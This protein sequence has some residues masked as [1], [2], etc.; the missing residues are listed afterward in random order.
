MTPDFRSARMPL[1]W[2]ALA[3]MLSSVPIRAQHTGSWQGFGGSGSGCMGE[4]NALVR[5]RNGD[6]Y[7][8]GRLTAC[9]GVPV[10][11]VARWDGTEW[12]A[13]TPELTR[14]ITALA[15]GPD[16]ELYVAE[17]L[18]QNTGTG[19]QPWTAVV[20]RWDGL[21]W[22]YV[23]QRGVAIGGNAGIRSMLVDRQGQLHLGIDIG[24]LALAEGQDGELIFFRSGRIHSSALSEPLPGVFNQPVNR[25]R[26][27]TNGDLL[28]GGSFTQIDGQP[29]S[30]V[31]RWNG[32]QWQALGSGVDGSVRD[33]EQIGESVVVVGDFTTAGGIEARGIARW[34]GSWAA[35]PGGL[36][37]R[38]PL[39]TATALA[40]HGDGF[41]VGGGFN[42]NPENPV[43]RVAR[44]SGERWQ[45]LDGNLGL[46]LDTTST[47]G[48]VHEGSLLMAGSSRGGR[49][50]LNRLGR[51]TG[52]GWEAFAGGPGGFVNAFMRLPSGDLLAATTDYTLQGSTLVYRSQVRQ[53]NGSVWS[54]LGP[55][56]P[57]R[58]LAISQ[59]PDGALYVAGERN[60][61]IYRWDGANWVAVTEGLNV[62]ALALDG[63]QLLV[64]GG[65]TEINGVPVQGLAAWDGSVWRDVGSTEL[66]IV[67]SI[68]VHSGIRD[69]GTLRGVFRQSNDT[70]TRLG[71]DNGLVQGLAHSGPNLLR[72]NMLPNTRTQV[73]R[74][75]GSDWEPISDIVDGTTRALVAD[76]EGGIY[77]LGAFARVGSRLSTNI[78]RWRPSAELTSSASLPVCDDP[79]FFALAPTPVAWAYPGAERCIATE[80]G[81]EKTTW[82]TLDTLSMDPEIPP[83]QRVP[84][85]LAQRLHTRGGS[86][87]ST[88]L[89]LACTSNTGASLP[90]ITRAVTL[91]PTACA[92]PSVQ[93]PSTL[94][95]ERVLED[96]A[97]R[98]VATL[99]NPDQRPLHA[100]MLRQGT[101]GNARAEVLDGRLVVHYLPERSPSEGEVMKDTLELLVGDDRVARR[102]VYVITV[103]VVTTRIGG[104]VTGLP[105]GYLLQLR[106]RLANRRID[107]L[108]A[109]TWDLGGALVPRQRFEIELFAAPVDHVCSLDNGAL[110]A[111]GT[112]IASIRDQLDR[113]IFCGRTNSSIVV[114]TQVVGPGMPGS[115]TISM[116][117]S[118]VDFFN[119]AI[120]THSDRVT[121]GIPTV[122]PAA[123]GMSCTT[124]GI[125]SACPAGFDQF[126]YCWRPPNQP[127]SMSLPQ[128]IEIPFMAGSTSGEVPLVIGR[129]SNFEPWR[130][131]SMIPG[132]IWIGTGR[133]IGGEVTGLA[134]GQSVRLRNISTG[135]TLTLSQ[136]GPFVLTRQQGPGSAYRVVVDAVSPGID[137]TLP[138]GQGIMSEQDVSTLSVEC[139]NVTLLKTGFEP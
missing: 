9:G 41:F 26:V 6:M 118:A 107:L 136:N 14:E 96:G 36:G 91:A 10:R 74:W 102:H 23:L 64:G 85:A 48:L 35:F 111:G 66:G 49:T 73:S 54:N 108:N 30:R 113:G 33:V 120:C 87:G 71:A 84:A 67:Y 50:P 51:W 31:A 59:G 22:R 138:N 127:Q 95:T 44:W 105:P 28:V 82:S 20:R 135:E 80:S 77:W 18:Q 121:L 2:I 43:A 37:E 42:A 60:M 117:G 116:S 132:Q 100:Q 89:S 123:N 92:A 39:V 133:S 15:L 126:V 57:G 5:A 99:V 97:I 21:Q 70:W 101:K 104:P 65:M 47:A 56:F 38:S 29:F 58:A 63:D 131:N 109:A 112:F 98:Y 115:F 69:V 119:F 11:G 129:Q 78:A 1:L 106:D 62:Y 86:A 137:C 53:W 124:A 8:G 55:D 79:T 93:V 45:A 61:P 17:L 12:T 122:P 4:I 139:A 52:K 13:V 134:A 7:V 76:G 16:D 27:A 130:A 128:Q 90:A 24:A 114:S 68:V 40:A 32:T 75:T 94:T 110:I 72:A 25:I 81:T 83:P 46:G 88:E 3:L 19:G 125:T 34:N 103:P